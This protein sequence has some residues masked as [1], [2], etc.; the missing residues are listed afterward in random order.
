M[1][2]NTAIR[3]GIA[4]RNLVLHYGVH[5]V[6]RGISLDIADAEFVCLLGPSG[7]GK[8]TLLNAIA[9]FIFPTAGGIAVNGHEV[10][11]PGAER[12]VVFQ[13]YAL[14]P[15]FTVEQNVQ[16]GP[17]L[18]GVDRK[19]L[20][21]IS[22][23]YLELVGLS[24]F[25]RH[26]PNQLSGGQRQ[27]VAIARALAAKPEILLLDEPFGALDAM[28]RESLQD[29]LVRIWE[30][31]RRTCVFVTHS[32]GEAVFLAETIIVMQAQPGRIRAIIRND[33]PRPRARTSDS[34]FSMYRKVDEALRDRT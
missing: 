7:C 4:I 18:A 22:D 27:R 12:G 8:T 19:A 9:G 31:E 21:A 33:A 28:T 2:D 14:F 17:R 16:Y 13:E 11:G 34:Y 32:I 15:W 20:N 24:D 10:R 30:A 29:E 5:E 26:Y 6:L 25:K 1:P 23:H 3:P